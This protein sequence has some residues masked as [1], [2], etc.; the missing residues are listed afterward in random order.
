MIKSDVPSLDEQ[1]AQLFEDDV[2]P[3]PKPRRATARDAA[4]SFLALV[5]GIVAALFF[6][7]VLIVL[8]AFRPR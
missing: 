7:G 8:F 4:K 6:V 3:V 2:I 5:A 1:L